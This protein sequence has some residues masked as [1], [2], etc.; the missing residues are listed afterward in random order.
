MT[1]SAGKWSLC[2]ARLSCCCSQIQVRKLKAPA[3]TDDQCRSVVLPK[4]DRRGRWGFAKRCLEAH[5]WP[6]PF[7]AAKI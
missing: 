4:A 5:V 2:R 6:A 3:A 1:H 7:A